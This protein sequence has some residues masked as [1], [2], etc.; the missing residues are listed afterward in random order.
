MSAG[1][2]QQQLAYRSRSPRARLR[3]TKAGISARGDEV[4]LDLL[5]LVAAAVADLAEPMG[6]DQRE[7]LGRP[8]RAS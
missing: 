1:Q 3:S 2:Q 8:C 7:A 5:M 4:H 6:T